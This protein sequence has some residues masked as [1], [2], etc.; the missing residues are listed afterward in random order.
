MSYT[1][2]TEP[3]GTLSAGADL[4]A[5]QFYAVQ[6]STGAL[7]LPTVAG[8]RCVG[9]LQ[10]APTSGQ[11]AEL[12]TTGVAKGWLGGT[13]TVD[14]R[15]TTTSAGKLVTSTAAGDHIIGI[16]LESGTDGKVVSVL[17]GDVGGSTRVPFTYSF[18]ILLATI[19]DGDLVT[20]FTPGFS[21]VITK[22]FATTTAKATT[23][24]KLSTLNVEIGT[25][26]TTGG[27]IALTTAACDTLGK[28]VESSAFT[29]LNIFT[30]TD[31]V[32]IEAASTT[33]FAEGSITITLQGYVS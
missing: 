4:S 12:K 21:G 30:S 5:K 9:L 33:A 11:A 25:T 14:D 23:A 6:L 32:S 29:A 2:N 10:N 19:A 8:Q 13:V 26:N 15:L 31:T 1:L 18:S 22:F 24:A 28:V 27:T 17:P 20:A 3:I 16:A 7:I